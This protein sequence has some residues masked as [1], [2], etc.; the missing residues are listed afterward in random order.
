LLSLDTNVV[1]D[2]LRLRAPKVTARLNDELARGTALFL[3]RVVL[4]E[5]R[6]GITKSREPARNAAM[7]AELMSAP[8]AILPFD[9]DDAAEAGDARAGLERAGKPIGP[10]DVLIGAQAR[11]RGLVLVSANRREFERIPGLIVTDWSR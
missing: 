10:Y 2:R 11:R 5:L 3:S 6:L 9:A 4:F 7:L 1:V 8:I